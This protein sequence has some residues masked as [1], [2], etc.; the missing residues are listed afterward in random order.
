AVATAPEPLPSPPIQRFA[1]FESR[2]VY[3]DIDRRF[4]HALSPLPGSVVAI[5]VYDDA[6]TF[7]TSNEFPFIRKQMPRFFKSFPVNPDGSFRAEIPADRPVFYFL[8]G[9]TGVA[10]RYPGS[11]AGEIRT[12]MFGHEQLRPG[13]VLTCTGCHRGHMIRPELI[14]SAQ[15][16]WG[17][18]AV[19]Q[20]SSTRDASNMGPG[21]VLDGYIGQENGRYQWVPAA[22][23]LWPWV[24]LV[25]DQPITIRELVVYPRPGIQTPIGDMEIFLSNG[26]RFQARPEAGKADQPFTV[27]VPDPA[28]ITWAHLQMLGFPS[29]GAPGIAE[30]AAHGDPVEPGGGALPAPVP[31]ASVAAGSLRLSWSRSPSP[32]VLGY[33]IFAG[34]SPD[35]LYIEWDVGNST[36]FQP[37]YLQPGQFFFQIQPYNFS[38]FGHPQTKELTAVLT[39]PRIDRITPDRGPRWGETDIVIEGANFVPGLSAKIGGE[40]ITIKSVTP[41]KIV[42][43][44]RRYTAGTFDVMVR[45]PGMQE[46][47]LFKAFVYE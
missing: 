34:P 39:P 28:P 44:T 40:W 41:E 1:V 47:I 29:G 16:N 37:E 25:W 6:Q 2:S 36:S 15:V 23:D 8:R 46:Y 45:N 30:L 21:R 14:P 27:K 5:D 10:A 13:E 26:R 35:N 38:R 32:S 31:S 33:K 17:R 18:L 22:T 7:T 3:A 42:G 24:R 43:L 12:P 4:T 9:P 20:G 19:A 11:Y